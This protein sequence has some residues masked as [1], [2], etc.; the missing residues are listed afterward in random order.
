MIGRWRQWFLFLWWPTR[1]KKEKCWGYV[2][3]CVERARVGGFQEESVGNIKSQSLKNH[4]RE[5]LSSN[6]SPQTVERPSRQTISLWPFV[7][8]QWKIHSSH[9]IMSDKPEVKTAQ[10]IMC[11]PIPVVHLSPLQAT[12]L[13]GCYTLLLWDEDSKLLKSWACMWINIL[14]L[15]ASFTSKRNCICFSSCVFESCCSE[16][17]FKEKI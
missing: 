10:F 16:E 2:F 15:T 9:L 13:K 17:R 14:R 7:W 12:E 8:D 1:K 5:W 6:S 3:P 11:W 4:W